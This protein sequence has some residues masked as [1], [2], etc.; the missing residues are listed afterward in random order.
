MDYGFKFS[1]GETV[2][3][4]ATRVE[5]DRLNLL[6]EEAKESTIYGRYLPTLLSIVERALQECPGGIQRHYVCRGIIPTGKTLGGQ[7]IVG[8]SVAAGAYSSFN[9]AELEARA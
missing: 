7:P 6:S 9:E 2:V 5:A 1:I 3:V 4:T 8:C